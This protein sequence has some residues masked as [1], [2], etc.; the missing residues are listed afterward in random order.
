MSTD[1][2]LL[3]V[4]DNGSDAF[5]A[6]MTSLKT[7]HTPLYIGTGGVVFP[8]GG[9]LLCQRLHDE[10]LVQESPRPMAR[11]ALFR[12]IYC[13]I[14]FMC[15][16]NSVHC[17]YLMLLAIG[18][19]KIFLIPDSAA[20][21]CGFGACVCLLPMVILNKVSTEHRGIGLAIA[22]LLS[23]NICT[24]HDLFVI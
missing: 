13:V 18:L 21:Q 5:C 16:M 22:A 17:I 12:S 23:L 10:V 7:I 14:L 2:K 9:W 8:S 4:V 24:A 11:S 6:A 20:Q 15:Y 1:N 3:S 19:N